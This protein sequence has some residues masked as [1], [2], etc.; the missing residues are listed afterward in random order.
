VEKSAALGLA[1][2]V[3]GVEGAVVCCAKLKE[4]T[5]APKTRIVTRSTAMRRREREIREGIA[6]LE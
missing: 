1:V 6:F 4:A 3:G 2:G 5:L